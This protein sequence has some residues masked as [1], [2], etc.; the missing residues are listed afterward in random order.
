MRDRPRKAVFP[1]GLSQFSFNENGAVCPFGNVPPEQAK[2]STTHEGGRRDTNL[3]SRRKISRQ[4]TITPRV[5][6]RLASVNGGGPPPNRQERAER[7]RQR[8]GQADVRQPEQTG[9]RPPND[10]VDDVP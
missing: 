2:A 1:R 5:T 7:W 9:R 3:F 8:V 10:R 4:F 6:P